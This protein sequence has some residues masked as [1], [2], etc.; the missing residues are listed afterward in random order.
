MMEA[1]GLY[2]GVDSTNPIHADRRM[3]HR[4]LSRG[5]TIFEHLSNFVQPPA[6]WGR[7]LNRSRTR[8]TKREV[9]I[10]REHI[11]QI[12]AS[13]QGR[14]NYTCRIL[15]IYNRFSSQP[16]RYVG[17]AA[18]RNG[19]GDAT[20]AILRAEAVEIPAG[21]CIYADLERNRVSRAYFEGWFEVMYD[22]IYY[23]AGGVY[24]NA[25]QHHFNGPSGNEGWRENVDDAFGAAE[26]RAVGLWQNDPR[27][28]VQSHPWTQNPSPDVLRSK[29]FEALIFTNRC[30][31]LPAY[32]A[33]NGDMPRGHEIPTVFEGS[34]PE[35]MPESNTVIWQ[36][37]GNMFLG[38]QGRIVDYNLA[39][40]KGY[41][42]M[43]DPTA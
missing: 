30:D 39:K 24:G 18:H 14:Q 11:G 43:W 6:F 12:R 20:D 41:D 37:S 7:Y 26:A 5:T 10:L 21:V 23:G 32:I 33:M 34:S 3:G 27:A 40:P 42:A 13:D 28:F 31:R 16:E 29:Q 15:P 1:S 25:K 9:E 35:A 4:G 36:Y 22:S 8:L 2:W 19:R 38:T 17:T